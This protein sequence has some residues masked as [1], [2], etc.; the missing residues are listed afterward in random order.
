MTRTTSLRLA[1]G[2]LLLAG[3]GL[4]Q[5]QPTLELSENDYLGEIRPIQSVSHLAQN[6]ADTP[7]AVTVLD[8]DFIRS[9]GVRTVADLFRF[10]PG[11]Q[12]GYP[13]GGRPVVSYHGL[14]GQISQ[15]VLVLVDGRS[16]Y[17]PYLF[18]GVDWAMLPVQLDDID[19]IEVVRGGNS[20]SYGANAFMGVIQIITRSAAQSTG[21]R[22][23]V[24]QGSQGVA[25]RSLRFGRASDASQYRLSAIERGD[26]GLLGRQDDYRSRAVDLR[27]DRQVSRTDDLSLTAGAAHNRLGLGYPGRMNDPVR[28][29]ITTSRF[30]SARWRRQIDPGNAYSLT[31]SINQS[32]GRDAYSLALL[33]GNSL[34]V[35]LGRQARSNT[36][37]Y[38]HRYDLTP[39]VR[40]AW[41][42]DWRSENLWAPQLFN[43][44]ATQTNQFYQVFAHLEWRPLPQWTV[45]A[46][47]LYARDKLAQPQFAPRVFVNWKPL[48]GQTLKVGVSEA[49][50]TPSLFEQRADWRVEYQGRVLDILYLTRARLQ[51][52]R[53]RTQEIVYLGEWRARGL[54]VDARLFREDISRLITGE[55]YALGDGSGATA[56]DLRNNAAAVLQG[57]DVQLQ[58]RPVPQLL[59][60]LAG[61][62]TQVRSDK[63]AIA[64]SVPRRSSSVL[65]S[66]TFPTETQVG[67]TYTERSS[68]NWLGE[69]TSA[70]SQKIAGASIA[71]KFRV[72][73]SRAEVAVHRSNPMGRRE[74]F[75][76]FERLADRW[77][78]RLT[79]EY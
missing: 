13:V 65:A 77:W 22:V 58:W 53:V 9:T 43:T 57:H 35:D 48:E 73:G 31:A 7:A 47:G 10:V 69:A 12:V 66:Y 30:V 42:A 8:R 29:E 54:S 15:R 5:A 45:N 51:P 70:Q 61:H 38:S 56:Y 76:E 11:F 46:G 21:A 16:V 34:R 71:Q 63:S 33:D 52:E 74:E 36:L 24:T 68:V 59:L 79:V 50:R 44:S 40:A 49:F 1:A 19:R 64:A 14:S 17:A 28:D 2:L 20:A 62:V 32:E 60:A 4:V 78:A 39:T 6:L 27:Y 75:R 26:N 18:G 41:G 72:A 37:G 3:A 23:E 25:D 67:L 55:L